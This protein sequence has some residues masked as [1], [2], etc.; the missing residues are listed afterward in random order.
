MRQPKDNRSTAG[1]PEKGRHVGGGNSGD[2]K[3]HGLLARLMGKVKHQVC[4]VARVVAGLSQP[5]NSCRPK[6][7]INIRSCG[8]EPV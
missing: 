4:A 2:A 7:N 8:P 5:D 3:K 6:V 1:R